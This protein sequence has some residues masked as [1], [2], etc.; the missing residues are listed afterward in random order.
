MSKKRK[1]AA[2]ELP[3]A[4]S[5]DDFDGSDGEE[6]DSDAAGEA[7]PPPA[8]IEGVGAR[9]HSREAPRLPK[10]LAER[11]HGKRVIVVLENASLET[12]KTNRGYQLLNADDHRGVHKKLK[13]DPTQSRPDICHLEL[14][15]LL[16]SPLNKAGLLQVYI[17]TSKNVLI[18]VNPQVR[19]PRTY[20]RFAGLMV[21]LLHKMK[22]RA[23]S[24]PQW[25]LRVVKNPV[26]RHLPTA[27]RKFGMSVTG[28]LVDVHDFVPKL[29]QDQPVVF[30]VGAMSHGHLTSESTPYVEQW[31][32]VSE[33][34]LSGAMAI[35]RLMGA[36]E[37]HWNIL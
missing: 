24:G 28:T 1:A 6:Y 25:L 26:L 33:Y 17:L 31:L 29:P 32:S 16:D 34:P 30:A 19:L 12:V 3:A 35:G 22:I 23:S 9:D 11:D 36:F 21:Q 14:M 8:P 20:K 7:Q 37:K 5:D 15:A 2:A 18:E 27:C 4:S 10:T 13:R